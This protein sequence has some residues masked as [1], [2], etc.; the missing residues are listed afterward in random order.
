[1]LFLI[2]KSDQFLYILGNSANLSLKKTDFRICPG[3]L[4]RVDLFALLLTPIFKM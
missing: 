3:A 4:D 2:G 1:M